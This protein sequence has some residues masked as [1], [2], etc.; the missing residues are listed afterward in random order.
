VSLVFCGSSGKIADV[1]WKE[2]PTLQSLM[3]MVTSS[4]YRFPTVDCDDAG[5]DKMKSAEQKARE[6]VGTKSLSHSVYSILCLKL[7]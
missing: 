3:K 2:H 5:R 6:E 7:S 4:K 1:M